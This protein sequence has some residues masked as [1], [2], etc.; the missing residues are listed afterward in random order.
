MPAILNHYSHQLQKSFIPAIFNRYIFSYRSLK[1]LFPPYYIIIPTIQL[2]SQYL[3]PF[4]NPIPAFLLIYFS[5]HFQKTNACDF[6]SLFPP[7]MQI[8]S[9]ANYHYSYQ[10]LKSLFPLLS[11][12]KIFNFYYL[13]IL[14]GQSHGIFLI[15]IP[16]AC[17]FKSL[18][19]PI[20]FI[21][22]TFHQH[23]YSL[24]YPFSKM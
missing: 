9:P 2:N 5:F 14:K 13:L 11:Y 16:N 8:H 21:S 12:L 4:K 22:H 23:P 17:H 10:L 7:I 18:F 6:K 20:I 15:Q 24:H 1:S 3:Q 19:L